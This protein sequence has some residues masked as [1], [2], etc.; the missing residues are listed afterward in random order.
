MVIGAAGEEVAVIDGF[1]IE[2]GEEAGGGELLAVSKNVFV[3]AVVPVGISEEG[4]EIER[5]KE[6]L[7][8]LSLRARLVNFAKESE[9]QEL[10]NYLS[11]CG[12][13]CRL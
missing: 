1:E 3:E 4:F 2:R 6:R 9:E 5:H 8:D 11:A 12:K 7:G 10:E 13:R